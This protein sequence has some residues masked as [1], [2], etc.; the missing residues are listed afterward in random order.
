MLLEKIWKKLVAYHG[1]GWPARF[2]HACLDNVDGHAGDGGHEAA[3]HRGAKVQEYTVV[4]VAGGH[5]ALLGLRVR[6]QL[7]AVHHHS[8]RHRLS[9]SLGN[10][11]FSL[12]F[13]LKLG[14]WLVEFITF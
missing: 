5:Q 3:D 13:Q 12:K 6:G 1:V 11:R 8:S 10:K 9:C 14:F 7:G 2:L 4:E